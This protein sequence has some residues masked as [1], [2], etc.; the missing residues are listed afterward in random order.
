L[1]FSAKKLA[2]FSKIKCYDQDFAKFSF[3]SNQKRQFFCA[4]K[5]G[6]NIYK[7]ITS[8]PGGRTELLTFPVVVRIF[9]E[10]SQILL[11]PPPPFTLLL[12][13]TATG[14]VVQV[15]PQCGPRTI[16]HRQPHSRKEAN[17][18]ALSVQAKQ[19]W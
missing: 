9:S 7:I 3:V 4:E 10:S 6:E 2:F 18:K 19:L 5:F 14:A 12:L 8:V 11:P 13:W 15:R 17:I 1:T 16:G